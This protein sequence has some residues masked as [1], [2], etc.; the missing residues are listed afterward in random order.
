MMMTLPHGKNTVR[1]TNLDRICIRS[2]QLD[3]SHFFSLSLFACLFNYMYLS[4]CHSFLPHAKIL[5]KKA[6]SFEEHPKTNKKKNAH[7]EVNLLTSAQNTATICTHSSSANLDV[8]RRRFAHRGGHGRLDVA[9]AVEARAV[10]V[11]IT[12]EHQ[13]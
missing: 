10:G 13:L 1:A 8:E 3:Y 4:V 7:Y 6:F 2:S 5:N 9:I 12:Q 11:Q